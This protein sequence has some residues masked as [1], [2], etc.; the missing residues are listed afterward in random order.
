MV[1]REI[2]MAKQKMSLVDRMILGS[3]KSEDY[4]RSKLPSSRWSLFFDIFKGRFLKLVLINL[5]MILFFIPVFIVLF[6]HL[7]TLA[8]LGD[9]VPFSQCFGVGYQSL[10]S[11][12]GYVES[13]S[14]NANVTSYIFLPVAALF[15]GIGLAG[16]AYII[17]NLVWTEGVFVANDFWFGIKQNYKHFLLMSFLYACELYIAIVGFSFLTELAVLG[18]IA[19]WLATII[20]TLIIIVMCVSTIIFFHMITMT[21]TY[22]LTFLQVLKNAFLMTIAMPFH[23]VFFIVVALLPLLIMLF[24]GIMTTV[25]FTLMFIF[26]ISFALLVWTDFCHW[27]YDKYINDRIPEAQKNRG[28]YPKQEKTSESL[29][30]YRQQLVSLGPSDLS[31]RPIKPITDD[32]LKL[33]ELPLSFNR[34]DLEK[35]NASKQAIYE[36]NER[37]VEEHK[38]DERYLEYQKEYAELSQEKAV[39]DDEKQKRIEKAKKELAKHNKSKK[40]KR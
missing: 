35:L 29:E 39:D 15:A 4:A 27:G 19:G 17:R 6:F 40:K 32:E 5:L 11:Y 30:Q 20:K 24:G 34:S 2:F 25:G 18:E 28:I 33:E 10:Y 8:S 1:I 13:I 37:Y 36:D 14:L 3:P 7:S 9:R 16:G 21:V 12:V 26:G 38:N 31:S 22:K 23:N